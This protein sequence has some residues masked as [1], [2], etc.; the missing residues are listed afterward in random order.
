VFAG[1][2]ALSIDIVR[3]ADGVKGDEATYVSMALSAAYDGDLAYEQRDLQRFFRIYNDGPEGLF[4]KRGHD[5]DVSLTGAFPFV[6]VTKSPDARVDRLYYAKAFAYSVAAAPFVRLA[7]LNGLLLFNVLL[8]VGAFL[9]AYHFLA[10]RG[11]AAPALLV[12]AAFFLASVATLYVV[13]LTSE[14]FNFAVVTYA[15]FLW[16][17]KY[18]APRAEG[19]WARFLRAPSSD[20]AA[21]LLFGV[22]IYSKLLPLALLA[23]VGLFHVWRRE[24]LRGV[25]MV[26]L[27]GL[28][29]AAIFGV[30][31]AVT[32]EVNYQGGDR[33]TFYRAF[34]FDA[35]DASWANRGSGYATESVTTGFADNPGLAART[36]TV[37]SWYF[38]VGRHTG[39]APYYFPALFAV[40]ACGLAWR[41]LLL[42]Q[43]L[44]ILALVVAAVGMMI[45]LPYTWAG[46]G[47]APGNRYF[48]CLYPAV[49]FIMPP[50]QSMRAA[51]IP[52]AGVLFMA[53]LLMNPFYTST[54]PWQ[55]TSRGI[56]RALP[57]ELTMVNDLPVMVDSGRGHVPFGTDPRILLYFMTA[58]AW[59]DEEGFWVA[60]AANAEVVVRA[61]E[62]LRG[63]TVSV[64]APQP[65]TVRLDAGAGA[66]TLSLARGETTKI[67]LPA[68]PR[69]SR[70]G[71]AFVLSAGTDRGFVP[72]LVDPLSPDE[73]FLGVQV[74]M[75]GVRVQ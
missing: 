44:L 66:T 31:A 22:A 49:F 16:L 65:N 10:V 15:C 53:P 18:V 7:G 69:I 23:P 61:G 72:H 51:L 62:P 35:P 75:T 38:L 50:I 32:G 47:G 36:L 21:A 63:L 29:A 74:R 20:V 37:N 4:L 13:W 59:P 55:E 45:W 43:W 56:F 27:A 26:G 24:W 70:G 2:A 67:F 11:P 12:S 54:H 64:H 71:Y 57:I 68:R 52:W 1:A 60:G 5:L 40:A 34:P 28:T 14:V 39:L 58:D 25:W 17:Y 42:P 33:K 3:T 46:G 41:R 6:R 30:Q 73:R 8:L 48:L 9:C 19:G